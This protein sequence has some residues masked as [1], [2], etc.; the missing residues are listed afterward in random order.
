MNTTLV[1]K[2]AWDVALHCFSLPQAAR[3]CLVARASDALDG[4]SAPLPARPPRRAEN[5]PSPALVRALGHSPDAASDTAR[6]APLFPDDFAAELRQLC[7]PYVWM[8]ACAHDLA[9]NSYALAFLRDSPPVWENV[10]VAWDA[11]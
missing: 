4:L 7:R 8:F 10:L 2:T 9:R 3:A 5:Q 1:Y 11:T 6:P